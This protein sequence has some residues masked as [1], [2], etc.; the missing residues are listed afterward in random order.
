M[1]K[2]LTEIAQQ[3]NAPRSVKHKKTT[4]VEVVTQVPKVQLI[5]AFNGTGKTR[6]S[7]EFKQLVAPKSNG[8][9][10]EAISPREKILYYNAFTEDLFYWDNDLERDVAP[11]LKIQPNTYTDWLLT[12][13]KDLGQDTNIVKYFQHFANDKLTPHFSENFAEVTFTLERGDDK[14]TEPLKISKGEESN[15]IWS[16]FY[17]LLDQVITI[18]NVAEPTE[19]ETNQFD[20]LEYVFIDDPVSSLDENHLIELAVNL[21]GLIKSSKSNL[22]FIVT[23]HSPL[24][25]NVLYNELNGKVCYLLERLEDGTFSL[26]EKHGDSNQS[27]SYHLYLKQKLE[28]AIAENKVQRYH[29]TLLRNLYEKTASFLGYPK[30][31]ELLP[32]DKQAY[33]NRII[34]FTS[35]STLSNEVVAEPSGPEKNTVG[36][37]LN[38]LVN[39]YGFWQQEQQND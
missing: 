33:L 7:R 23:T 12:L 2:T 14:G 26:A 13:L 3:L 27:F 4:D 9:D 32:D 8:E 34:Q 31:S 36:L 35:H 39:N 28:N 1:S 30:W 17:T 5:Y 29:F 37:L 18:L 11:K 15:F 6:L 19:R 24:F 22:K 25:Y 21:A 16:V 20:Q 10:D 38:H